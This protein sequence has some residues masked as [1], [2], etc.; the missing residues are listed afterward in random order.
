MVAQKALSATC[1]VC[2]VPRSSRDEVVGVRFELSDSGETLPEVLVR[3]TAP[4]DGGKANKAVCRLIAS[5]AGIAKSRVS[6]KR[7]QASRRKILALE[8]A[9]CSLREWIES[10]PRI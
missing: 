6:V 5:S 10:L 1:A 3:V 9:D 8:C 4:P 7:G 2:V